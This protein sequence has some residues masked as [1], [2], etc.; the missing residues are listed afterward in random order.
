MQDKILLIAPQRQA[1][2]D[3]AYVYK[4]HTFSKILNVE[5]QYLLR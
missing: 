3:Y 4:W 5:L 2:L 1:S